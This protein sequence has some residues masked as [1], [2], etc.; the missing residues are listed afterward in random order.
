[1]RI[2]ESFRAIQYVYKQAPA[3]ALAADLCFVVTTVAEIAA[4]KLGGSFIDAATKF[5]A[6]I[7]TFTIND[8]IFSDVFWFLSLLLVLMIIQ[9]TVGNL[10]SYFKEVVRRKYLHNTNN[11]IMHKLSTENL[12]EI[13]T[14][15]LQ[16]LVAF[17]NSFSISAMYD[18]YNSFSEFL[19]QI[20]RVVGSIFFLL[21]TVGPLSLFI[22]VFALPQALVYYLK[23]KR[24]AQYL[25]D[26]IEK[27]KLINYLVNITHDVTNFVELKVLN[28][29]KHMR[30]LY[31]KTTDD[32]DG[33]ILRMEEHLA[34]DRSFFATLGHIGV[35]IIT[36]VSIAVSV[37]K[38]FSIGQFKAIYDYVYTSYDG[39]N[40]MFNQFFIM[41]ENSIYLNK[42]FNLI[43]YSGFGD[44]SKGDKKLSSG[45]PKLEM[46]NID[47][48]YPERQTKTLENINII[49]KPGEKVAIIGGDGS[50]KSTLVKMLC[51]LYEI[52]AG[53]YYVNDFSIRELQR[54][55]LKNKLSIVSQDYNNYYFSI[56][57][58][59][60]IGNPN[61]AINE[62]LYD[63]AKKLTGL[64]VIL[65]KENLKDSQTLGKYFE[66]GIE[67]SPGYWQRIS[68]ARAIYRNRDVLIMDEP[69]SLIDQESRLEILKN[70]VSYLGKEKTLILISQDMENLQF[71]DRVYVL[72][73]G[74]LSE[75]KT[76]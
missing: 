11:K 27:V 55:E 74:R 25:K 43:D 21:E 17:S 50:G 6:D 15:E 32:Y 48:Q 73:N 16:D 37:A 57:R 68:I 12:Q 53:D 24:I 45:V 61:I 26:S 58:N 64:D 29:F 67:V 71:F 59:I 31:K 8:F 30:Q 2:K 62:D 51:G 34:I 13:E 1:M 14:K 44:V 5:L 72:K 40:N 52:T 23:R 19:K 47:F 54:G 33:S 60:T 42:F 3:A 28:E 35:S 41:A 18:F 38:K 39:I 9:T 7:E 46:Q 36:V 65:K 49:V 63:K 56:K 22:F 75:F 10:R 69:F 66:G 70:I 20:I 76:K 4:I